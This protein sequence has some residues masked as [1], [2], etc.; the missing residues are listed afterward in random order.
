MAFRLPVYPPNSI[1]NKDYVLVKE[2][3]FIYLLFK[4]LFTKLVGLY[5]QSANL[6]LFSRLSKLFKNLRTNS[7][8][9]PDNICDILAEEF[10]FQS[11]LLFS[12][13]ED[14]MLLLGKSVN[15]AKEYFSGSMYDCP[16]CNTL[17]PS[18]DFSDYASDRNCSLKLQDGS[19]AQ[20]CLPLTDSSG[21]RYILKV[22]MKIPPQ[23]SDKEIFE[24]IRLLMDELL[25]HFANTT[26]D[27]DDDLNRVVSNLSGEIRTPV[28]S[29][30]GFLSL[31]G[32]EKLNPTQAEYLT[33]LKE[34]AYKLST[35]L[36][37]MVDIS[38]IESGLL[39]NNPSN[40]HADSL[41]QEFEQFFKDK[42][43]NNQIALEIRKESLLIDSGKC[44]AQKLKSVVTT[45]I[46]L[47]SLL[48]VKGKIFISVTSES[49]SRL[50]FRILNSGEIH[51]IHSTINFT[52]PLFFLENNITRTG[53]ISALS[54]ILAKKL[55][56]LMG[57][58]L[59]IGTTSSKGLVLQ[60]SVTIE[61]AVSS[62]EEKLSA[63][64]KPVGKSKVLVIEDDYATSKLLSNYLNKWGYDP[65]IVNSG[66]KA[67]Q[68][69]KKEKFLAVIMDIVL[70]DINGLELLKKIRESENTKN[71]PVIVCS[72]EAEQQKAFLMGAVEYFVK[73]IKY[74]DLVE[75]LTSYKLKRDSNIL[76][77]DDDVPTLNLIKG[78]IESV[79]YNAIAESKSATVMEKIKNI[80]LD[81]AIVDL[82]MPEV[83][84]FEL[85]KL[86]KSNPRFANLPIIIYTGKENF[87]DDLKKIDGLFADLLS[88]RSTKIEDLAD[89]I[90][91]MINRY[92]EPTS[93]EVLA[94]QSK[95]EPRILLVEDYKHSQI[96]V[97]RLLKKNSF[98][99]IIIAE[100]GAEAL[101]LVKKQPFDL[102]L[103]DMQM[104]IMNGFDATER[105][106]QLPEYKNTPIIALT[107]F[108]MKGDREK[109]L[110]AGASDYIAKPIDSQEFI[111]K[112]KHYTAKETV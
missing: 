82:D 41:I 15:S 91:N 21:G 14:R 59:D 89:T 44:D 11:T 93:P 25:F 74:K 24:T 81:L 46:N 26:S 17:K 4:C 10:H 102:I 30:L 35:L 28:N 109:C 50:S 104:P 94:E 70:P 39:L 54:L 33:N 22:S 34:S 92:D 8:D 80:H 85:I 107:A 32:E 9:F 45:F 101:E 47:F 68:I 103:M 52:R 12:L 108:A 6:K 86:I 60:F 78:A 29:I 98:N 62:L 63:L 61:P 69:I 112:V 48:T 43:D 111:E 42:N 53:N 99:S 20:Y 88:K 100:N 27:H 55:I 37:E 57:G 83:N 31:L 105:I 66:E 75:V 19:A 95:D 3:Y 18:P 51:P 106:R 65:T 77:V 110:E 1:I 71:I 5:M 64:P 67:L 16:H 76:C 79:G 56:E 36:N 73:P 7:V 40:F 38:K 72:V 97:T 90:N 96:I 87:S 23:K 84:G 58:S 13:K 49:K 2:Y